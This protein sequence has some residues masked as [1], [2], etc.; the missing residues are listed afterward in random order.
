MEI[1]KI[2]VRGG[3]TEKA[4]GASALIDEL[5][6]DRKVKDAVIKYL[7]KLGYEVL[8]VTPSVNYTSNASTDLA[9]GV[10]K[11]NEWGADLFVSIHFNKAYDSYNGALGSEVCVYSNYDIA[12]RVVNSLESLGFKNRGQKI[13]TG[14]YE[15]RNTNMKAM[16]VETCFVEATEDVALYRRLGHDKVGQAI[17]EAIVNDKVSESDTPVK[18]EEVSKPVQAPV[19]NTDDWVA[20]LQAECNKQGFS[21]QKVD[22]IP[23]ANTLKGCPTLKKGASGNITKL[24]QE[25]LV[26]LG[27]NTNGVDGIFGSGTYT[28]VR[29]FQK[30]RGLSADGIVGQNTWRKLLNL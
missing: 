6:E 25:K 19:S 24:L 27:Y 3:H 7:R 22:G 21:N 26:K 15:L 5:T 18:K 1:K 8:D 17:A 11:A 4:T 10:N 2:A 20:R 16:I 23:G 9:Y 12:Q 13:R 30:T 14:L 29:E 28:A